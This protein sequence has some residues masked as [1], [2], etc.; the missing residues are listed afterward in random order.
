MYLIFFKCI[1]QWSDWKHLIPPLITDKA[2]EDPYAHQYGPSITLNIPRSTPQSWQQSH[3]YID[4]ETAQKLQDA[5]LGASDNALLSPE[6][7]AS[8]GGSGSFFEG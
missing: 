3:R 4:M 7:V 8:I 6:D 1:L 5:F 2:A